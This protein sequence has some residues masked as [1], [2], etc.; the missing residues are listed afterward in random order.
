MQSSVDSEGKRQRARGKPSLLHDM[1]MDMDID[2]DHALCKMAGIQ[3]FFSSVTG[4]QGIRR[5]NGSQSVKS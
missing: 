1:D 3:C 2:M 4:G 5:E